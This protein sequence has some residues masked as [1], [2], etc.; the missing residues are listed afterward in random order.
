[1]APIETKIKF[2]DQYNCY[3]VQK[4]KF[5]N[6]KK[7]LEFKDYHKI[8]E[9][10]CRFLNLKELPEEL[11]FNLITL[12]CSYNQIKKLPK[13]PDSLT[14][15]DCS[16]NKIK[17]LPSIMPS[18]IR[19]IY[20]SYNKIKTIN[21]KNNDTLI[22]IDCQYNK[23]IDLPTLTNIKGKYKYICYD[24][25]ITPYLVLRISINNNPIHNILINLFDYN[26]DK[27]T[28][29]MH[30]AYKIYADK[31]G[32]WFLDCKYDPQYKYCR[33]KLIMKDYNE[34]YE[35]NK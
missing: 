31:I 10:D 5:K 15:L 29:F 35:K 24:D 30:K 32:Q 18:Y 14:V 3:R 8:T 6:F 26:I 17:E 13:L 16:H 4:K 19:F 11:P 28:E 2:F 9:I 7:L 23:L 22:Y 33:E 34:C 1:M 12:D 27:Y 25:T 20:C 21:I